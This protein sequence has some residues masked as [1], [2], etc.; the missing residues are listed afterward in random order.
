MAI[1]IH[2]ATRLDHLARGLGELLAG[3]PPGPFEMELLALPARGMQRWLDQR[4][5]HYLGTGRRAS[6][7]RGG[8]SAGI[9]YRHPRSLVELFLPGDDDAWEADLL[10]WQVLAVLDDAA[11]NARLGRLAAHVG[12]DPGGRADPGRAHRRYRVARRV[13]ER[14]ATYAS[15]RPDLLRGWLTG[16]AP[17]AAHPPEDLAWQQTLFQALASR[18]GTVPIPLRAAEALEGARQAGHRRVHL[19]GHTRLANPDLA[20][21]AELGAHT[22]VHLWLPHPSPALWDALTHA[23]AGAPGAVP[24]EASPRSE[25]DAEAAVHPL[26]RGL[27]REARELALR[28]RPLAAR[29]AYCSH[30]PEDEPPAPTLLHRL[31]ADIRANR[32][33]DPAARPTDP[34]G[35]LQVHGCHSKSRQVEVL[36]EVL[37]GLFEDDP[38]LE[39]RDVLILCPDVEEYAPLLHAAFGALPGAA[40]PGHQLRVGIADRAQT[41]TNPLFELGELLAGFVGGRVRSSELLDLLHREEVRRRFRF[42]SADVEE[43]STWIGESGIRWGFTAGHRAAFHVPTAQNTI[44]AGLS[45]LLLGVAMPVDGGTVGGVV[46]NEVE[47]TDIDLLGAFAEL[48]HRLRAG[49]ERLEGARSVEEWTTGLSDLVTAIACPE[50]EWQRSGFAR[51]LARVARAG[52]APASVA[53]F[54]EILHDLARPRSSAVNL[55]TGAMT[56][57]T[58][59]PMRSIPHKVV[60]LIGMDDGDFPRAPAFDADDLLRRAPLLGEREARIEDRQLFLDALMSATQRLI[61]TYSRVGENRGE[62]RYP[63]IPVVELLDAMARTSGVEAE[64]FLT[65]HPL[66]PFDRRYFSG[67]GGLASFDAAAALAAA[68]RTTPAPPP[69]LLPAPVPALTLPELPLAELRRF[70]ADPVAAFIR[71][72]LEAR[73]GED[74]RPVVDDIPVSLTP[75]QSWKVGD[76]LLARELGGRLDESFLADE[77]LRGELP[78]AALGREHLADLSG[79]VAELAQ[80]A[81][82]YCAEPARTEQI[83]VLIGG[84]RVAGSVRHVYGHR[85][86]RVSYSRLAATHRFSAWIDLLA[87]AVQDPNRDWE[88]LVIGRDGKKTK[89]A[90]LRAP[91]PAEAEGYLADLLDIHSRG[92]R[93]PLP[94]PPVTTAKWAE[95][96][97]KLDGEASPSRLAEITSRVAGQWET[98][99]AWENEDRDPYQLLAWGK[100]LNFEELLS[101]TPTAQESWNSQPSRLGQYAIRMWEPLLNHEGI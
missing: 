31:Q 34:D 84:T 49:I 12:I 18:L 72:R 23:S 70:F 64:T 14:F 48:L 80:A 1:T 71:G 90:R 69:P 36:R 89:E 58:L 75:L 35:S 45:R 51:A 67:E 52:G 4:L 60:C 33:P 50:H 55:S 25:D 65:D 66:H 85:I 42:T 62:E 40:H 24:G 91:A 101:M 68:A 19:F 43:L 79:R 29:A 56:V 39:P 57:A 77:L 53:D 5:S 20:F 22:H 95:E 96:V 88:A 38:D 13:A 44:E 7:D 83:S 28:L 2:H 59:V 32:E 63:A 37:T 8:I 47:S 92:M 30:E 9:D 17:A 27:G 81:A 46:P 99:S 74:P 73:V 97:H 98:S 76:R 15:E 6:G 21:L 86:V 41:A 100:Q 54:R 94:L 26:L 10:A 87:L 82:P 78:P 11:G 3:E 93:E 16:E 61:V